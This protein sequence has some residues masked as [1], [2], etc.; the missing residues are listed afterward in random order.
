MC[1]KK[2]K[3]EVGICQGIIVVV[4]LEYAGGWDLSEH[5]C[6]GHWNMLGVGICQGI[7]VVVT[8]L[9]PLNLNRQEE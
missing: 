7:T 1:R 8:L 4:T 5:H 3:L 2:N 9:L 6:G